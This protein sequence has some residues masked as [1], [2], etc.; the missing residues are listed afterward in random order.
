M[1]TTNSFEQFYFIAGDFAVLLAGGISFYRALFLN[2]LVSITAMIGLYVG[3]VISDNESTKQWIVA[4]A[5][6]LFI[7]ISLVD[8]VSMC[9]LF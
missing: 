3:L 8:L 9:Y 6:G 7:Y 4:V 5:A 2:V 1:P